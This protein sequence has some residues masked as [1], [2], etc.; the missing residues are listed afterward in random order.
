MNSINKK[1][2]VSVT[3]DIITDARVRKVC[4]FL[5]KKYDLELIGLKSSFNNELVRSYKVTL[6]NCFFKKGFF[7]YAEFNIKLFFVILFRKSDIL[8]SNDLDTLLPNYLA[9]LLKKNKIVY[10]SHEYFTETPELYDRFFVRRVWLMIEGFI[11]PKLKFTYTVSNSIAKSY[12]EKYKT[13][14]KVVRNCPNTYTLT[15][16][17]KNQKKIIFQGNITL[18][19]GLEVMIKA[20]KFLPEFDFVVIGSGLGLDNLRKLAKEEKVA[21]RVFF[22]GRVS[23]KKLHKYTQEASLGVLFEENLGLSFKYSLPNKLFDYIHAEIPVLASPLPEVKKIISKYN[24]GAC[25]K[26]RKPKLVAEQVLEIFS[27]KHNYNF[28]KAKKDFNWINET[29]VLDKLFTNIF[30]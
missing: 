20:L 17:Q 22:Q 21:D 10:D 25:L 8:L 5:V 14:M 18:G 11:L 13:N 4:G 12:N 9:S 29:K 26:N 3:N 30:S 24:I 19:R 2:I 28:Q 23:S 27:K 7:F 16:K 1:V 15:K 6:I